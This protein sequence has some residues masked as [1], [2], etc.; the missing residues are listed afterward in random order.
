[1]SLTSEQERAEL[2]IFAS[3]LA[4][5]DLLTIGSFSPYL[6]FRF[7]HFSVFFPPSLARVWRFFPSISPSGFPPPFPAMVLEVF[8]KLSYSHTYSYLHLHTRR[9]SRPR[10]E[11][12]VMTSARGRSRDQLDPQPDA[13][14][15]FHPKFHK[16]INSH[17]TPNLRNR[18]HFVS[19]SHPTR[20]PMF[21]NSRGLEQFADQRFPD[22]GGVRH[23][24][25]CNTAES[26]C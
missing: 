21:S 7:L 22:G 12:V 8:F 10:G 4:V 17:Q 3:A 15:N 20:S 25:S 26:H 13:V 16:S 23:G 18:C 2:S 5:D 24:L 9:N 14:H 1:M 11:E 6:L 19:H